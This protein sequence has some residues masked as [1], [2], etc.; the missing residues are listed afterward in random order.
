[1]SYRHEYP[2]DT[3]QR[4]INVESL[5]DELSLVADVL[6]LAAAA[7]S[8]VGARRGNAQRRGLQDFLDFRYRVVAFLR[9]DA[10]AHAL[11]RR[12]IRHEHLH[13]FVRGQ[14]VAALYQ[15]VNQQLNYHAIS[16]WR[17]ISDASFFNVSAAANSSVF[18]FGGVAFGS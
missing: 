12:G 11:L 17:T 16:T 10:G 7:G 15:L 13:A 1:V 3:L 6:E 5:D 2:A 14:P 9:D 18:T 8:V 4:L